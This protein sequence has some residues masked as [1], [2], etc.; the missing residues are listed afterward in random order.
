MLA[1]K[2]YGRIPESL[3]GGKHQSSVMYVMLQK[4]NDLVIHRKMS[5]IGKCHS[6]DGVHNQKTGN[7]QE[8]KDDHKL[9]I[10]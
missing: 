1:F 6:I 4:W 10:I 8:V 9:Y 5:H 2:M 7:E 3:K